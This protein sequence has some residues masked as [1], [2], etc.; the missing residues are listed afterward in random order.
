MGNCAGY[1]TG[2]N[3]D[4]NEHH[5]KN[6]FNQRDLQVS[7]D[8][9]FEVRY[10]KYLVNANRVNLAEQNV[11]QRNVRAVN[12]GADSEDEQTD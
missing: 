5:I 2:E 9:D 6:S 11:Q 4:K 7:K 10:G 3:E 1:C 8:A 12:K